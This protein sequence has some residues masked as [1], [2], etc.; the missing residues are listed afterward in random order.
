MALRGPGIRN[1]IP[2]SYRHLVSQKHSAISNAT[3]GTGHRHQ[4]TMPNSRGSNAGVPVIQRHA[5]R[6]SREMRIS[7]R[8]GDLWARRTRR[9]AA[10]VKGEVMV[11]VSDGQWQ[12]AG[13]FEDRGF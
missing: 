4:Q 5:S 10:A 9:Y 8:G 6:A 11:E 1:A 2:K 7:A 13:A 12:V 3:L